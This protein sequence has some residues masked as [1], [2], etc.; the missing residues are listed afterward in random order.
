MSKIGRND[1]CPC[2][3]GLKFKKCHSG[4]KE[5]LPPRAGPVFNPRFNRLETP[6]EHLYLNKFG[7]KPP[8]Q[9]RHRGFIKC[10]LLHGTGVSIIA[11]D[12]L[13]IEGGTRWI[14]PLAF[15]PNILVRTDDDVHCMIA[16]DISGSQQVR[17]EFRSSSWLSKFEDGS[18]L[19]AC[20]ILGPQDLAAHATGMSVLKE[21]HR[22]FL[23]L[24][25]HTDETARDGILRDG[26]FRPSRWNIQG[27][28][29]LSNV[30]YTY[31]TPLDAIRVDEDLR[32]IAMASDEKIYFAVDDAQIPPVLLP[33]TE[34]QNK[35]SILVLKVYRGS[36]MDRR[37]T[38][39]LTVE[40]S[41]IAPAHLWI[42][43][44][45]VGGR[46][47]EIASPFIHRIG[48][49]PTSTLAFSNKEVPGNNPAIKRFEYVVVGDATTIAGLA[50]PF[51]EEDTTHIF[52]IERVPE[53][54]NMLRYWFE[55]GNKDLYSGKTTEV[56]RFT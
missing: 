42:H 33:G 15:F 27:N 5:E 34:E 55:H 4:R 26:A 6:N 49:D 56:Q 17:I 45:N 28:K 35:D 40:A 52:K 7:L 32:R 47:Y 23:E 14:Q 51:D 25:H 46:F 2:G 9:N 13:F 1:P 24:Y 37:H 43:T 22:P 31:L 29:K 21:G 19:F 41:A 53:G 8:G 20:D 10:K 39:K 36:T 38:I 50:A 3:S 16:I 12:I 30:G 44:P 54:S 48:M 18:E 11:P